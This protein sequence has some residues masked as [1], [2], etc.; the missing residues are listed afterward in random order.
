[1]SIRYLPILPVSLPPAV[2]MVAA[3]VFMRLT[4]LGGIGGACDTPVMLF[5]VM[6][7]IT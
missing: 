5:S 3:A 7:G 1:M 4:R 6:S 2:F